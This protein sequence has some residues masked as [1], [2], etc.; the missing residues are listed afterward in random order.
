LAEERT[1]QHV[2]NLALQSSKEANA[3]LKQELETKQASLTATRDK[4]V[5]KPNA[6]DTEVI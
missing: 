1:A 4:L 2:A 3:K 5:A 6:L